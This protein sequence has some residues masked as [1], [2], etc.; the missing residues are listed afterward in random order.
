LTA[1]CVAARL[2]ELAASVPSVSLA[3]VAAVPSPRFVRAVP[4]LAM[5]LRLE[6][7]ASASASAAACAVETGLLASLVLSTLLRPTSALVTGR[8]VQCDARS[9]E[10]V[11]PAVCASLAV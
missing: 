3:S 11:A 1:F 2:S 8:S 6:A 9:P 10:N 5:S 4:A 7:F